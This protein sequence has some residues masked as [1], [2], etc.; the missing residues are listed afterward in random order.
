MIALGLVLFLAGSAALLAMVIDLWPASFVLSL[1]AYV[2]SFTGA[3][4]A[5]FELAARRRT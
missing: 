3:A 5:G 4:L 2:A 1:G